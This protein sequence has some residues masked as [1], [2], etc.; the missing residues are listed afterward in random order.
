MTETALRDSA[1]APGQEE[2]GRPDVGR[3]TMCFSGPTE[4]ALR[5][6]TLYWLLAKGLRIED[7]AT[8]MGR[9]LYNEP[10]GAWLPSFAY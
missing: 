2:M 10:K 3:D 5:A 1:T 8:L 7:L 4:I 6:G 9:G